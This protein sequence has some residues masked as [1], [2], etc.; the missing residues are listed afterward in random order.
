MLLR[1]LYLKFRHTCHV[2]TKHCKGG[3]QDNNNSIV[4]IWIFKR[5]SNRTPLR[6]WEYSLRYYIYIIDLL[7]HRANV[8]SCKTFG[9]KASH[10]ISLLYE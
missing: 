7:A 8:Q 3:Q 6:N 2:Y 9:T 1:T 10:T 5:I 4:Y